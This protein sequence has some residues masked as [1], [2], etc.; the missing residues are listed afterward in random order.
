M[1]EDGARWQQRN[2]GKEAH[3]DVTNE[4]IFLFMLCWL[5]CSTFFPTLFLINALDISM[6]AC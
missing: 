2:Y 5:R 1:P 6:M 4:T 3:G